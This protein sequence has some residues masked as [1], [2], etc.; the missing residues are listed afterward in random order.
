[1]TKLLRGSSRSLSR[2]YP[3]PNLSATVH[4]LGCFT[5]RS[6][7]GNKDEVIERLIAR[8]TL[9]SSPPWV[10]TG[11]LCQ[12]CFLPVSPVSYARRS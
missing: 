5:S 9:G 12:I 6:S 8:P 1:M 3:N 4:D 11:R 10:R 2:F 7:E